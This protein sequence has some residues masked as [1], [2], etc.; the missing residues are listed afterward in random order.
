MRRLLKSARRNS[1]DFGVRRQSEAATALWIYAALKRL[2]NA[3]TKAPSPLR[4][5]GALQIICCD[6]PTQN[7]MAACASPRNFGAG[8]V[9]RHRRNLSQGTSLQRHRPTKSSASRIAYRRSRFRLA[10]AGLGSFFESL[11]LCCPFSRDRRCRKS[12]SDVGIAA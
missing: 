9:L 4:S 3:K 7:S 1:S 10:L 2:G 12:S 8:H 11:S 5:A 6:E